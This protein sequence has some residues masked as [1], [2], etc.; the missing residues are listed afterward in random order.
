MTCNQ[1]KENL[2]SMVIQRKIKRVNPKRISCVDGLKLCMSAR[3]LTELVLVRRAGKEGNIKRFFL[4]PF[5]H[6]LPGSK[7]NVLWTGMLG[8]RW[9]RQRVHIHK[10][11]FTFV[12]VFNFN[13][14][15]PLH[16]SLFLL[17]TVVIVILEININ[18]YLLDNRVYM[19]LGL[20]S[21]NYIFIQKRVSF[22]I[23]KL[24]GY[25]QMI[26]SNMSR[27]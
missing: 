15:F 16:N 2:N 5:T 8:D 11:S 24:M 25:T 4:F 20:Y 17:I 10:I 9:N 26:Y 19:L 23:P 14:H 6:Q 12:L 18:P 27:T 3:S 1:L 22:K 13:L 21:I 7:R